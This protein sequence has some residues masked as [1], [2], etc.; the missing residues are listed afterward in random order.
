MGGHHVQPRCGGHHA[1]GHR[2]CAAAAAAAGRAVQVPGVAGL[3][4]VGKGELGGHGLAEDDAALQLQPGH[5][6]SVVAGHEVLERR[7][8][9]GGA[10]ALSEEDVLH[11][12]GHA[13]Q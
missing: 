11:A 13:L 1:G 12:E 3:G 4:V 9:G 7:E 6:L 2:G 5:G 8:V 10:Q